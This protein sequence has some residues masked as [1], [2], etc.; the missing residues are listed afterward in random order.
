MVRQH[1]PLSGLEFEQT[2]TD[3]EG[4]GS[5]ACFG[6]WG[7]K[8]SERHQ[9]LALCLYGSALTTV[10][11]HWKDH[12]LDYMDLCQQSNV[13]AFQ[14]TV[15]ICYSSPAKKQTSSCL[16]T[17]Q[18]EYQKKRMERMEQKKYLKK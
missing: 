4:E 5:L 7:H 10:H 16:A 15:Q 11:D 17:K 2:P 1:H 9:F 18:L 12:S 3:G 14:H 6:P 13:S 8:E